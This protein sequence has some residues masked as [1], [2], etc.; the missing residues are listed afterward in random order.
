MIL[1]FERDRASAFYLSVLV[2][3]AK[4]DNQAQDIGTTHHLGCAKGSTILVVKEIQITT[5]LYGVANKDAV[6]F[7]F[8]CTHCFYYIVVA[9]IYPPINGQRQTLTIGQSTQFSLQ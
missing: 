7:A 8:R 1:H 3:R 5:L 6:S 9:H 4:T 2:E